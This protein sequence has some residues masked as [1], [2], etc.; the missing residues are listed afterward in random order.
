MIN[1]VLYYS[2]TLEIK[3]VAGQEKETTAVQLVKR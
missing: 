3:A 2:Q 1:P